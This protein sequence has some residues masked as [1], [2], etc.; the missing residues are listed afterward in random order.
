MK[1]G[2]GFFVMEFRYLYGIT[3]INSPKTVFDNE[4]ATWDQGYAD[5]VF[6]INSLSVTASYIYNVF[7]PKKK[8]NRK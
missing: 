1:L 2:G 5:P 3:K 4:Q 7:N 8:K 6:K